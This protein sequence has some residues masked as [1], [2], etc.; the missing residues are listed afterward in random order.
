MLKSKVKIFLPQP[1]T[2]RKEK[3]SENADNQP[4]QPQILRKQVNPSPPPSNNQTANSAP[5]QLPD[6]PKNDLLKPK[7]L[8]EIK[9]Y[10]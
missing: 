5:K 4:T 9:N 7:K 3:S 8:E 6:G 2:P 1:K 10:P